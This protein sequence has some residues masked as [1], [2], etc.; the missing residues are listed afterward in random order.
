MVEQGWSYV[1]GRSRPAGAK[2][3]VVLRAGQV[4]ASRWWSRGGPTCRAGPSQQVVEQGWSYVPGRSR[5]A[6]GGAGVVLR[7]GQVPASRWWSRGGPTCRAGPGQ[8]VVDQGWSYVP[9]RSRPAGAKAGATTDL[10]DAWQD[11]DCSC[12]SS[13][14]L[15]GA[16]RGAG[17]VLIAVSRVGNFFRKEF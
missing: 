2:A 13:V 14:L 4:P 16:A 17:A 3:G 5:P 1:P 15:L 12:S 6:G 8:Q 11:P 9:G 7:A 10:V